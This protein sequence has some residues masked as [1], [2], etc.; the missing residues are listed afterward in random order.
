MLYRLRGTS[1]KDIH[2]DI[3]DEQTDTLAF[4]WNNF[5]NEL[6]TQKAPNG[7]IRKVV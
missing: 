6:R 2:Q 4:A 3:V 7:G 5:L 1:A